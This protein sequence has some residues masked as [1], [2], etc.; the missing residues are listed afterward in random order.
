MKLNKLLLSASVVLASL[1]TAAC[2]N[3]NASANKKDQTLHLMQTGEI[4]L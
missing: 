3:N 2:G 1:A 4:L